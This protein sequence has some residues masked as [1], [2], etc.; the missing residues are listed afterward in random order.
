M[1]RLRWVYW[2]LSPKAAPGAGG[3]WWEDYGQNLGANL[4]EC[5]G[6]VAG[7]AVM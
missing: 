2:D 6:G 7:C 3:V 5:G 4:R 1:E